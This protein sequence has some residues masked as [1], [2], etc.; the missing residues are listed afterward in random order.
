MRLDLPAVGEQTIAV[1]KKANAAGLVLEE[2]R[3][4]LLKPDA[5]VRSADAAGLFIEVW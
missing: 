3:A 2:K 4:L 5:I 1:L